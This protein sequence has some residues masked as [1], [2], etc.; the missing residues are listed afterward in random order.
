MAFFDTHCHFTED[1]LGH[2]ASK[3]TASVANRCCP[4]H[5]SLPAGCPEAGQPGD[6]SARPS[7]ASAALATLAESIVSDMCL[8]SCSV[9]DW[10][11][12]AE[13]A[14]LV[15]A[16]AS[17]PRAVPFFGVHPWYVLESLGMDYQWLAP[18]IGTG[19]SA[20][21]PL[22][23]VAAVDLELEATAP[24]AWASPHALPQLAGLGPVADMADLIRRENTVL[25]SL[26]QRLEACPGA[27]VGEIGLDH[28]RLQFLR[29]S[30]KHEPELG[31]LTELSDDAAAF[32][33]AIQRRL[34]ARQ[35]AL[36]AHQALQ[37]VL[38]GA[39]DHALPP[40]IILHA[41]SGTAQDA[42][43]LFQD[44]RLAGRLGLSV[45]FC[46]N[47]NRFDPERTKRIRA[48]AAAAGVDPLQHELAFFRRAIERHLRPG[49]EEH[50]PTDEDLPE[51]GWLP[52]KLRQVLAAV[53]TSALLVETDSYLLE[54]L[55]YEPV[56]LAR[57]LAK[58]LGPGDWADPEF[59][60]RTTA[61]NARRL[62]EPILAAGRP[63][64]QK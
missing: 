53:P 13:A 47:G 48:E 58:A 57:L 26:A 20:R 51:P 62:L 38:L 40:G 19:T 60:L 12:V 14:D 33:A 37:E 7:A 59:V 9:L 8:M 25:R 4:G 11:R 31:K 15:S 42:R 46:I 23:P 36:A 49:P 50:Q 63:A 54:T 6:P 22:F 45:A 43:I 34:F 41:F 2:P 61:A 10:D 27:G 21:Q 64:A 32:V 56:I 35:L 39:P 30:Q 28:F 5:M 1:L 55:A 3:A 29:D 44:A 18:A 17:G 24:G 52:R 16:Q